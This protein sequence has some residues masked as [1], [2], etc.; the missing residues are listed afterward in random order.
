[1]ERETHDSEKTQVPKSKEGTKPRGTL[2]T[3][4]PYDFDLREMKGTKTHGGS[5]RIYRIPGGYIVKEKSLLGE[6]TLL[7]NVKR[8]LE[9]NIRLC[10][11]YLGEFFL[12]ARVVIKPN[13]EGVITIYIIQKELPEKHTTLDPN[14]WD[15]VF[16][17][18]IKERL[19]RMMVGINKMYEETG[20]MI[21]LL[22][23]NNVA[24]SSREKTFYLYD[25]DPLI[26][27]QEKLN[28]LS[29][30]LVV[31]SHINHEF[32]ATT[33]NVTRDALEANL[34]NFETLKIL[35]R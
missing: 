23:L 11:Q 19:Q 2:E 32:I 17:E 21:D 34:E 15:M 16:D 22:T 26:C 27:T 3:E 25:C 1:M 14:H 9:N 10:E 12:R 5:S 35:V 31:E 20:A 24:F 4:V 6:A 18:E 29:A 13:P 30:N 28:E 33:G 7:E 8:R